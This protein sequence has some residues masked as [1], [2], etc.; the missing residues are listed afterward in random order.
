[1]QEKMQLHME[2]VLD[3]KQSKIKCN[4]LYFNYFI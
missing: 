1:M 3:N 4:T 2:K